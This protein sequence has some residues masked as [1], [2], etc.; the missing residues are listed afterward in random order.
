MGDGRI[1][2]NKHRASL[3]LM[4]TYQMRLISAGY[5]SLDST[6]KSLSDISGLCKLK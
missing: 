5:I 3:S 4:K 1:F 6:F 2:L